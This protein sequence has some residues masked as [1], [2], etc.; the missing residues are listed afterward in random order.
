MEVEGGNIDYADINK[1]CS[2]KIIKNAGS[3]YKITINNINIIQSISSN[4]I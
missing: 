2:S 1:T 3:M 4:Y